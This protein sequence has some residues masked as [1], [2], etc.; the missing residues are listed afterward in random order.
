[1][2]WIHCSVQNRYKTAN[3]ETRNQKRRWT[4]GNERKENEVNEIL[5]I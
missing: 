4:G 5:G 2:Q 3:I 1:M